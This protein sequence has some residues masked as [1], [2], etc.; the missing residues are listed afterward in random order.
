MAMRV[1][2]GLMYNAF[3][4]NMNR[5]LS[6]LMESN[7]QG[8]SQKRVNRP[9]DDPVASGR[10]LTTRNTLN[11]L[12]LY[13]DNMKSAQG[14][15]DMADSMLSST[16]GGL[17]TLLTRLTE[18]AEQG[19]PSTVTADNRLEISYELR[20]LFGQILNMSNT[21]YAGS[22]IFG[23][24]KTDRPAY[25]E[26]LGVTCVDTTEY[27]DDEVTLN[28]TRMWVDGDASRTIVLQPLEDG[29]AGYVNYRY[30][31][32]GGK[33][34][35]D[36]EVQT[37]Y[38][39]DGQCTILAGGA[40]LHIADSS[41]TVTGVDP[42]DDHSKKN[43]TW[44]YLRP[45]AVYQGDDHDTQVALAYSPAGSVHDYNSLDP[46]DPS[47][48][49]AEGYFSRDVVVRVDDIVS[50]APD[51]DKLV[52]SYSVDNGNNWVQATAPCPSDPDASLHLAI[53]GG[54]VVLGSDVI[55]TAGEI[56]AQFVVHP[57]R[58][59]INFQIGANS[60]ISANLIGKDVF[61]GLYNYPGDIDENG[62][63]IDYP[64]PV[65][66]HANLF[67]IVGNL[68][69]AAET[70][71][72][73]GFGQALKDLTEANKLVT[74]RA[75]EVGGRINRLDASY[76]SL[77]SRRYSEESYLSAIEDVDVTQLM[78]R[79]AQQENAYMTVLKSSSMIMQMSLVNFL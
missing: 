48:L 2:Q 27:D 20:E 12:E 39:E 67:E 74:T 10:I 37:D 47:Y 68:I 25:Q 42:E 11:T 29:Q 72:Q 17:T 34:W 23:G 58:A 45:T 26:A 40:S 46:K 5:N 61:G 70:N 9:S 28:N 54:Y 36:A 52:Y 19:A 75:A 4:D 57:N 30:S 51:P 8:S 44:L 13:E 78:T 71:N 73:D 50:N 22:H 24:H 76:G 32:D 66:G 55:P 41:A 15:L 38:P 21:Q 6:G 53:P 64:V 65:T 49:G 77:I 60:T 69:A 35:L 56:G 14:W 79:M 33:T 63:P 62:E 16:N 3:V 18:L 31:M 1:T 59:D 7:I 43:G